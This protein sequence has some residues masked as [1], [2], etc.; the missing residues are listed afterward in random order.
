M[1]AFFQVDCVGERNQGN[2]ELTTTCG[3]VVAE[4]WEWNDEMV[5]LNWNE[6]DENK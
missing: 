1:P 3:M 6:L 2:G 5:C 4:I